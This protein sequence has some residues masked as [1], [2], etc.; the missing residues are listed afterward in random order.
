MEERIRLAD[1]DILCIQEADGETFF[2]DFD[3][4]EQEGYSS[5]LHKKFRFR[6]AT[7]FKK[8][9]WTLHNQG[10]KDRTLLVQL[11]S[12]THAHEDEGET[13]VYIANCHLSGGAAPE[14]RLRQIHEVTEQIRK[15]KVAADTIQGQGHSPLQLRSALRLLVSSLSMLTFI[16]ALGVGCS[17]LAF[18]RAIIKQE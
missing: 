12:K 7:F 6:C 14:R 15:W 13:M 11:S 18:L 16:P 9:K 10:H 4:M 2:D 8:D 5:V 1:P 17:V 3:F